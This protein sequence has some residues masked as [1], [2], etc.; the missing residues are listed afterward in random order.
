[1]TVPG[2]SPMPINHDS[3]GAEDGDLAVW[4]DPR[5]GELKC[6]RLKKEDTLAPSEKRGKNHWR[7]CKNPP[8]RRGKKAT[9]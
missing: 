4:R 6:R 8:K 2:E 7:T 3:A 1:M 9:M 5:T